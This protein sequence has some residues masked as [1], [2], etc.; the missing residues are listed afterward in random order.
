MFMFQEVLTENLRSIPFILYWEGLFS[1]MLFDLFC[2]FQT[3]VDDIPGALTPF[4]V[5][6]VDN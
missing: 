5:R 4:Q 2:L 1:C 6:L 3:E